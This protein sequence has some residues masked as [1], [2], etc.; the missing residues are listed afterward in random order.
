MYINHLPRASKNMW[1]IVLLFKRVTAAV[2]GVKNE[3]EIK[4]K[5]DVFSRENIITII[6]IIII[7]WWQDNFSKVILCT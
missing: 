2:L 5:K 3:Y 6:I 4:H 1:N 7:I